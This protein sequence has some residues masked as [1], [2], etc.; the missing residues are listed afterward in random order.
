[1]RDIAKRL[2]TIVGGLTIT[3]L[4]LILAAPKTAH[5]I[6]STLVTVANTTTNP[7]PTQAVDN[8]AKTPFA[9]SGSCSVSGNTCSASDFFAVPVGMTAVVQDVSGQCRISPAGLASI[10]PV[11]VA[12]GVDGGAPAGGAIWIGM[13]P[14]PAS[15]GET[16]LTFG[17]QATL[18]AVSTADAPAFLS[19]S[20]RQSD[21]DCQ[22][23][24][25]GYLVKD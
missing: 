6:V 3:A 9:A 17:R 25:S 12:F 13:N 11:N 2:F 10:P 24:A 1:M 8:P 23:N 4:V 7:V 15:F 18:Y 19:F 22:I 14:N 16:F 20:D 21:G 5:A